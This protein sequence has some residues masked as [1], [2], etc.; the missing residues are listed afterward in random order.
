MA[1]AMFAF[2]SCL[3]SDEDEITYY[4]DT[5]VTAF[6]LSAANRYIHT[7]ASDGVTDSV[8]KTTLTVTG[9][10]FSIDQQQR[11]IYNTDSLPLGTDAAHILATISSKNSGT[12]VLNLKNKAGK[13][14]LAYYSSTDSIDFTNPVR[15][16][17]YNGGGTAYRE[18]TVKVNI[19][20][21]KGDIF[22]WNTL[23]VPAFQ[24]I[25]ERRLLCKGEDLYLFG[26]KDGATV[27]Y[28]YR[29]L[30]WTQLSRSFGKDAYKN[31]VV[32]QDN[33]YLLDGESLLCSSDGEQ[34][35][36][37]AT[38]SGVKQLLGASPARLY[39]LTDTGIIYSME[40]RDWAISTCGDGI[41]A[42]TDYGIES[43][44]SDMAGELSDGNY[45][46]AFCIY[47]SSLEGYLKAFQNGSPVD[48]FTTEYV[49]PGS[50]EGGTAEE[51]IHYGEDRSSWTDYLIRFLI[52]LGIGA[53]AGGITLAGLKKSMNTAVPQRGAQRAKTIEKRREIHTMGNRIISISR[54]FGSGGHEVAVK[55]ADLLGIRVY[56]RELIRL[57][58]EYGELS[59]KTL[60]PSDEKA[61][62]PYL[63][64][65]VHE[66]NHHV[67]RGKPTSE[68]L[69][70]LQSHEIR[71]IARHE[72]C[73]FV[74]RCADYV[75]R[76]EDV[77]LLTV[78]V[79]APDEHRIQRT[80]STSS[81]CR[82][83]SSSS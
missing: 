57:A 50:Y 67:L 5:A 11:L 21:Q 31:V 10:S 34:W 58:C 81:S 25:T 56:E 68:V 48:G 45:Y 4:D 60:S 36:T 70:A 7:T 32:Q 41:Y 9:Y 24:N 54:Q 83:N 77:R 3:N 14:S 72:E 8:Y 18:Y 73:V 64:Q 2:S 62:N 78:F 52:A 35:Q 63:F 44:F 6:S 42:L 47:L 79:A 22:K 74:G 19:H 28:V 69:F 12:I 26:L 51:V 46:D 75:L 53:A 65:T 23:D 40:Y 1:I 80:L 59:E 17:V 37:V 38:M 27:G 33:L 55:T 76:G 15:I 61:T 71:R 82:L 20:Q 66:G 43:V 29:N 16:R 49:G 30:T 39:A 13:D